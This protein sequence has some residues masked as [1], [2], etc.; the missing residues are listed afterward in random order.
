[1]PRLALFL[2]NIG[3]FGC[4]FTIMIAYMCSGITGYQTF[5]LTIG[6]WMMSLFTQM[7]CLFYSNFVITVE[8]REVFDLKPMVDD[9]IAVAEESARVDLGKD[10]LIP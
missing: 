5:G 4:C 2:M 1:M 6:L 9:A 8:G 3:T 10:D 7:I